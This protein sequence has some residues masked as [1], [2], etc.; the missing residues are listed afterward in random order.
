MNIHRLQNKI[1]E[2]AWEWVLLVHVILCGVGFKSVF[3]IIIER[4]STKNIS[5]L[6]FLK[7]FMRLLRIT[8][9]CSNHYLMYCLNHYLM[10]CLF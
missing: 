8:F 10:Y 5:L 4:L 2:E 7:L 1:V 9:Y 3:V 6:L